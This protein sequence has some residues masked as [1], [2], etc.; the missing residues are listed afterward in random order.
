MNLPQKKKPSTKKYP[1]QEMPPSVGINL[2]I[3]TPHNIK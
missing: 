1:K 3:G 2:N